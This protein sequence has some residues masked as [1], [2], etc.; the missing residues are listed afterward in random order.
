MSKKL[1]KNGKFRLS[2]E[3]IKAVPVLPD[4]TV[5]TLQQ[6]IHLQEHVIYPQAIALCGAGEELRIEN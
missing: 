6:R 4:D 2:P 3:Y 5:A 1:S